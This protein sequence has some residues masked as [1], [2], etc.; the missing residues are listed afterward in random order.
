M[1]NACQPLVDLNN[2]LVGNKDWSKH[3]PSGVTTLENRYWQLIGKWDAYVLENAKRPKNRDQ[4]RVEV[5]DLNT[6]STSSTDQNPHDAHFTTVKHAL[7]TPQSDDVRTLFI[8]L[9]T[10]CEREALHSQEELQIPRTSA[11]TLFFLMVFD[12]MNYA[13]GRPYSA[14]TV[15]NLRSANSLLQELRTFTELCSELAHKREE[16]GDTR[17]RL[18]AMNVVS[19]YYLN[20]PA[21]LAPVINQPNLKESLLNREEPDGVTFIDYLSKTETSYLSS[22]LRSDSQLGTKLQTLYSLDPAA[23]YSNVALPTDLEMYA[24]ELD[25]QK[26]TIGCLLATGS[27]EYRRPISTDKFPGELSSLLEQ[28]DTKNT[29]PQ[30]KA[31]R[32]SDQ[33]EYRGPILLIYEKQRVDVTSGRRTN[34]LKVVHESSREENHYDV[35]AVTVI[36][37]EL[38]FTVSLYCLIQMMW[39]NFRVLDPNRTLSAGKMRLTSLL[40]PSTI[41]SY[42]RLRHHLG[43]SLI[44]LKQ[45]GYQDVTHDEPYQQGRATL[46]SDPNAV[47]QYADNDAYVPPALLSMIQS[48]KL[49]SILSNLAGMFA[50]TNRPRRK[51]VI[52]QIKTSKSAAIIYTNNTPVPPNRSY[53]LTEKIERCKA[54]LIDALHDYTGLDIIPTPDLSIEGAQL[55]R[56]YHQVVVH[57][58]TALFEGC[59]NARSINDQERALDVKK[60]LDDLTLSGSLAALI[61]T[62]YLSHRNYAERSFTYY[63][64]YAGQSNTTAVTI[65]FDDRRA[66][67]ARYSAIPQN[68]MM[69]EMLP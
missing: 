22:V 40:K 26:L 46:N 69:Q 39:K 20:D 2:K 47:L 10:A 38:Q 67:V 24:A 52:R 9:L 59:V 6:G 44:T 66:T 68:R 61:L 15:E 34:R 49:N 5:I 32:P 28:L 21:D 18:A 30:G 43:D 55:N 45:Q 56:E 12:S 60:Q 16:S 27:L 53:D 7:C 50:K 42:E 35:W 41:N 11:V 19:K 33:K 63:A 37:S 58:A 64:E 62:A 51:S 57:I 29:N 23:G 13:T 65:K 8:D 25:R 14:T 31:K 4:K 3:P 48:T 1:K 54:D 36:T 17:L